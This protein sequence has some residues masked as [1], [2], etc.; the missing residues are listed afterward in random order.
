M[1]KLN[2]IKVWSP[3][4]G[5]PLFCSTIYFMITISIFTGYQLELKQTVSAWS[6]CNLTVYVVSQH[7]SVPIKKKIILHTSNAVPRKS[8]YGNP[9][10]SEN[11]LPWLI[12][13]LNCLIQDISLKLSWSELIHCRRL[14]KCA[15]HR[16]EQLEK[17]VPALWR[18]V[19]KHC[20]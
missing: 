8:V 19:P 13:I 3:S 20:F 4:L 10:L 14:S 18:R 17:Y 5:L 7:F 2:K 16:S 1:T 11:W 9:S 15:E 6:M 12:N